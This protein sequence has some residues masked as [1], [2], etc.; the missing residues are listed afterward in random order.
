[1][2]VDKTSALS[3]HC[4]HLHTSPSV[5]WTAERAAGFSR[6]QHALQHTRATHGGVGRC[7][8]SARGVRRRHQTMVCCRLPATARAGARG[9]GSQACGKGALQAVRAPTRTYGQS[10]MGHTARL[11]CSG[12]RASALGRTGTARG[13]TEAGGKEYAGCRLKCGHDSR[14]LLECDWLRMTERINW[15]TKLMCN[16]D[17]HK[18]SA[19]VE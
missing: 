3:A 14:E 13:G 7:I 1:M 19:S 16:P 8:G 2:S 15:L 9:E 6:R 17:G 4:T 11:A 18:P 5:C 10:W 12:A